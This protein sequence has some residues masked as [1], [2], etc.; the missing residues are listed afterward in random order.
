MW[1]VLTPRKKMPSSVC[2]S[3]RRVLLAKVCY[4]DYNRL[5]REPWWQQTLPCNSRAVS[6]YID[7][8]YYHEGQTMRSKF[9]Q[10]MAEAQR[11]ADELNNSTP[12]AEADL[13]MSFGSA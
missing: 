2:S 12:L 5:V 11:R 9:Q 6:R 7:M 10:V 3:Y 13:L 4:Y 8:G 1:V